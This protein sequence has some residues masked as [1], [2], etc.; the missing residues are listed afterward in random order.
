[1]LTKILGIIFILIG[2]GIFWLGMWSEYTLDL[3]KWWWIIAV[4]FVIAG[5]SALVED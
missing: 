2:C 3:P 1:M 5:A 4:L